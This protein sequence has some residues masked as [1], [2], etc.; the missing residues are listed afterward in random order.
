MYVQT[1]IPVT[2]REVINTVLLPPPEY[3][4]TGDSMEAVAKFDFNASGEDELS[5]RAGDVL[6]VSAPQDPTKAFSVQHT[7]F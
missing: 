3:S 1:V 2:S 4:V 7:K 5:F 6:K